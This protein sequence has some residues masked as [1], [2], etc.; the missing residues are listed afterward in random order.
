MTESE[1]A[2]L[3][4]AQADEELHL[5][6]LKAKEEID[7]DTRVRKYIQRLADKRVIGA[8]YMLRKVKSRQTFK[9]P[10][11]KDRKK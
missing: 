8:E 7:L 4:D 9:G 11:P 1:L 5:R 2:E 6:A 10:R 3:L